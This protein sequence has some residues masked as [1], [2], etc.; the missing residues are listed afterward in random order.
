MADLISSIKYIKDGLA[1]LP[2]GGPDGYQ[3]RRKALEELARGIA[4]D[5][6]KVKINE[7]YDGARVSIAGV[8]AS[9][10]SGIDGALNNWIAAARRQ[11][12]KTGFI[13]TNGEKE[14]VR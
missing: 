5:L 8:R 6:P 11:L 14:N 10:T 3:E 7:R 4:S 2:P 9:S 1:K 13:A 12:D